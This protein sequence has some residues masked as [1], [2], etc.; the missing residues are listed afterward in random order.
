[1][2]MAR[3]LIAGIERRGQDYYWST[4]YPLDLATGKPG[5][6]IAELEGTVSVL[7]TFPIRYN[8]IR[9]GY[10]DQGGNRDAASPLQPTEK[11]LGIREELEYLL[12]GQRYEMRLRS[13]STPAVPEKVISVEPKRKRDRFDG[14]NSRFNY[15]GMVQKNV[16]QGKPV[17]DL[18]QVLVASHD[19]YGLL[20]VPL[21]DFADNDEVK[22]EWPS[23]RHLLLPKD[24][25]ALIRA[26]VIEN[27]VYVAQG[28]TIYKV[29]LSAEKG[30]WQQWKMSDR[31]GRSLLL[32][33]ENVTC[34]DVQGEEMV[35]GT[36]AGRL[37]R[38]RRGEWEEFIPQ[39][40]G[41]ITDLAALDGKIVCR[42]ENF[43]HIFNL[44]EG[45][46]T[47]P[48]ARDVGPVQ[49]HDHDLYWFE[50]DS[51]CLVSKG[52]FKSERLQKS[53]AV[54]IGRD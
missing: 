26:K 23:D 50:A 5:E 39:R 37:W 48:L 8:D 53:I 19:E 34:F 29:D 38:Y 52:K 2:N 1:M 54:V 31:S 46:D 3:C 25:D 18:E 9:T 41:V 27:T 40:S 13:L 17:P 33:L 14:Y 10:T 24:N 44:Y 6:K 15:V 36:S 11:N 16:H 49:V 35:A 12:I 47:S 32:P 4:I 42:I 43:R 30:Q 45:H 7:G 28:D 22:V 20:A 51:R 21:Q